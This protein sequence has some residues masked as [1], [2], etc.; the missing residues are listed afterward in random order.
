MD[1]CEVMDLQ[2]GIRHMAQKAGKSLFGLSKSLG[3][4]GSFLSTALNKRSIPRTDLFVRVAKECG[5]ELLLVGHEEALALE[6]GSDEASHLTMRRAFEVN[7]LVNRIELVSPLAAG[8]VIEGKGA[9]RATDRCV[10]GVM[11]GNAFLRHMMSTA[12]LGIRETSRAMGRSSEY[13]S[14]R[15]KGNTTPSIALFE[16]M[17]GVC[18]YQVFVCGHGESYLVTAEEETVAYRPIDP[19]I[20][21]DESHWVMQMGKEEYDLL[22]RILSKRDFDL[23]VSHGTVGHRREKYRYVFYNADGKD[24]AVSAFDADGKRRTS[25]L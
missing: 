19:G 23:V 5:Y 24:V 15:L 4:V 22:S 20:V 1:V 8:V 12:G 3:R 18:G 21:F 17:A 2:D 9:S 10:D 7:R 14:V 25:T 16:T 13:M 6:P 11:G